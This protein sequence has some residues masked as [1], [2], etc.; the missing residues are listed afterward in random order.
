MV[1][2][3]Q[4]LRTATRAS[5]LRIRTNQTKPSQAKP[6]QAKP[7]QHKTKG[8][9]FLLLLNLLRICLLLVLLERLA[10]LVAQN[11][12]AAALQGD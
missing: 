11:R 1:R 10:D 7:N 5:F 9:R 8:S 12:A 3:R 4:G 2:R 6:S